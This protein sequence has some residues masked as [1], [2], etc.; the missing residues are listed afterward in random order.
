MN[1]PN[2]IATLLVITLALGMTPIDIVNAN[3]KETTSVNLV[4]EDRLETATK[5]SK[6]G[7]I[8][9]NEAVIVNDSSIVDALSATSFAK[10]KDAPILLTSKD[11]L[12][13][14]TKYRLKSLGVK[15]IYL[16]GGTSV[17]SKNVE[18]MLKKEGMSVERI[19]G[20][21]RYD[22]SLQL[23]KRVDY[24]ESIDE[25]VVV[26]GEKGLAD[27]VSIGAVAAQNNMPIILAHPTKG[28]E[29]SD[30]FIK[31]KYIKNTYI[32]GGESAISKS[33]E[34]KLP[35][36]TR[37]GGTNRNETNA[38]VI[39]KFYQDTD[40]KAAYVTKDGMKNPNQL[41]DAL[42]VGVLAAKNESPIILV[43][44]KLSDTQK[45]IGYSKSFESVVQV[46]GNGN[47]DAFNQLLKM[48]EKT[49]F[50]VSTVSEFKNALDKATSNDEI[51]FRPTKTIRE[52]FTIKSKYAINVS[53]ETGTY[54]STITI[55]MPNGL[56][57]NKAEIDEL[58]INSIKKGNCTN[59]GIIDMLKIYDKNEC[60]I[61]NTRDGK[62]ETL[63][64]D[65]NS[66]NVSIEN[67]GTINTIENN[68]VNTEINNLGCIENLVGREDAE[69]EGNK[70]LNL[71]LKDMYVTSIEVKD[72]TTVKVKF[73]TIMLGL[74]FTW[75]GKEIDS[76]KVS[77]IDR[78][79]YTLTVDKMANGS[80]HRISIKKFRYNDYTQS[81]I[82][83]EEVVK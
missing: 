52:N 57:T 24:I 62:I 50:K 30:S 60:K 36:T 25:I 83:Y 76:S 44:D 34:N 21:D 27:A 51:E 82:K 74:S 8:S 31:S 11:E 58:R 56:F 39:E 1:I 3:T 23:A 42:S 13:S 63:I 71:D 53:L 69:I 4:G 28:T 72:A 61:V 73:N 64:V 16:I 47:E 15:R 55:D 45:D 17:L 6:N 35:H 7:W 78:K 32:I 33:I 9:S 81:G 12:S 65:K 40:L 79:S 48:Q 80:T 19:A 43:S 2:K 77:S 75:D 37:I 46:G 49:T 22:T 38:R 5:I 20:N 54:N 26:N 41:I 29:V 10:S 66:K 59:S 68:V 18:E 70:P 14:K 67:R